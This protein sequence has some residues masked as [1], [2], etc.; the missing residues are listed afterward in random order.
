MRL[1]GPTSSQPLEA[2]WMAGRGMPFLS[3]HP[4]PRSPH[5]VPSEERVAA[6]SFHQ[7]ILCL[8]P[9]PFLLLNLL[10]APKRIN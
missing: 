10:A 7:F 9:S 2:L 8:L 6:L 4:P 1:V 5:P 3:Q